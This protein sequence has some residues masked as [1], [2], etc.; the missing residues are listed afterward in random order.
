MA[1]LRRLAWTRPSVDSLS[2]PAATTPTDSAARRGA[3]LSLSRVELSA[4]DIDIGRSNPIDLELL[5]MRERFN[6][7]KGKQFLLTSVSLRVSY[8]LSQGH[9]L[10]RWPPACM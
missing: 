9:A 5:E 1:S 7:S 6:A 8:Y 2:L 3:G 4:Y 10:P